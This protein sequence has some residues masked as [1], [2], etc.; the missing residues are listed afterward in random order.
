MKL[1]LFDQRMFVQFGFQMNIHHQLDDC[2]F[3]HLKSVFQS[4]FM[5]HLYFNQFMKTYQIYLCLI[6]VQVQVNFLFYV[7]EILL[8]SFL[9][10]CVEEFVE[11]HRQL[12]ESR[13]ISE[14]L[15][16]WIDLIFGHKVCF[17][18]SFHS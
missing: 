16:L 11:K 2:M 7:E 4:S 10:Y 3:G 18:C 8:K 15:H 1:S 17:F 12:L 6:G 5:I 14:S 13:E 9:F